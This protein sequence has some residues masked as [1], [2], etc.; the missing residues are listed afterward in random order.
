LIE[1]VFSQKNFGVESTTTMLREMYKKI[2][3]KEQCSVFTPW[4]VFRAID[5][6]SVGGMTYNG[7]ETLWNV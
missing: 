7:L 1:A 2:Y 3:F 6:S 4:K 5:L